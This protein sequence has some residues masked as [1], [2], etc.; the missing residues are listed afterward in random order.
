MKIR[1]E[2]A[3]LETKANSLEHKLSTT[4]EQGSLRKHIVE[5]TSNAVQLALSGSIVKQAEQ[6]MKNAA[7]ATVVINEMRDIMRKSRQVNSA[8]FGEMEMQLAGER[9]KVRKLM[10]KVVYI[11]NCLEVKNAELK[12]ALEGNHKGDVGEKDGNVDSVEKIASVADAQ[13][14]L[15]GLLLYPDI[16]MDGVNG[17][18]A[19]EGVPPFMIA[20][21]M[22]CE[23]VHGFLYKGW[24]SANA[25][26]AYATLWRAASMTGRRGW[27]GEILYA[28][29]TMADR[30]MVEQ[31][32][33][34]PDSRKALQNDLRAFQAL[35]KTDTR[36]VRDWLLVGLGDAR[37]SGLSVTPPLIP[38]Y[39]SH[40][41]VEDAV[42]S[43]AQKSSHEQNG[44]VKVSNNGTASNGT[45]FTSAATSHPQE[46][47]EQAMF[48][49]LENAADWGEESIVLSVAD[50]LVGGPS[51]KRSVAD[52][53]YGLK[54]DPV[55]EQLVG[56]LSKNEIE[57]MPSYSFVGVQ[58]IR[59]RLTRNVEFLL[60]G[61]KTQNCLLYGPPGCGKS[62]M[63]LSFLKSHGEHGLRLLE[64]GKGDMVQLPQI[65]DIISQMKQK[66]VL[67]IDDL[68]FEEYESE[69]MRA[70]KAALEGSLRVHSKNTAVFVTSNRRYPVGSQLTDGT[71]EKLAFSHRF[72]IVLAF[73]ATTRT[74]YLKIV[75]HL[76]AQAK[77][78]ME[79]KKL[80][81]CAIQWALGQDGNSHGMNGR[82][83]RQF[84]DFVHSEQ[85]L[86]GGDDPLADYM[87]SAGNKNAGAVPANLDWTMN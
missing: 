43:V 62:S 53:Y 17:G 31:V 34:Q 32:A 40:I 8:K 26:R 37:S 12:V 28:A 9:S 2:K 10:E 72:G 4:A 83:A 30:K 77:I 29:L 63:V 21:G 1:Q 15:A 36:S 3:S 24:N 14:C 60:Q 41:G 81:G 19:G 22:F 25:I 48:Q 61:L 51:R 82:T 70:G 54:W 73:P 78:E 65:V 79:E 52:D 58:H 66:F 71:L 18:W 55:S 68:T 50:Y 38:L 84:V 20:L 76:A 35:Y 67:F 44:N 27:R 64:I 49:M 13:G 57:T 16:V 7:E 46:N 85:S 5:A 86:N 42:K 74:A 33:V 87:M 69:A 75:K 47:E 6:T 45:T 56:V 39:A 23:A 59:E 80:E 11:E